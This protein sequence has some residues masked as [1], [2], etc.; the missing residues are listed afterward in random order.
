M[1][2]TTLGF[3]SEFSLGESTLGAADIIDI[4]ARLDQTHVAVADTMNVSIMIPLAKKAKGT[5]VEAIV[6][7]RLRI[8]Q[9]LTNRTKKGNR[10]AFFPKVYPKNEAGLQKIFALVSRAFTAD[11]FFH[12][13]RLSFDDM[14]E[15]LSGGDDVLVTSGDVDGIFSTRNHTQIVSRIKA[16][17]LDF[18]VELL[19]VP[20]PYYERCN[21]HAAAAIR[22]GAS[23][24]ISSPIFHDEDGYEAFYV[25]HAIHN[26]SLLNVDYTVSVPWTGFYPKAPVDVLRATAETVRGMK[27]IDPKV[28]GSMW[29]KAHAEGSKDFV[30]RAAY[31][32]AKREIALPSL[33]ADPN[34]A[35]VEACQAGVKA[36]LTTKVF[37][38]QPTVEEI[39]SK[40]VPRLKYELGVLKALGFADYFLVTADLCKWSKSNDVWTG[41]GRGSV[42]GSLVAYLMGITDVDPIRFDLI[43]E[44]FINPSR[45]DLPDADLDFMSARRGDVVKYLVSKYGE[46]YVAGINNYGSLQA[47]S[48]VNAVLRVHGVN[49]NDVTATKLVPKVHG[50]PVS[51][52]EAH[53]EVGEIQRFAKD[54]PVV[55]KQAIQMQGVM[56]MYSQHAAGTII[57]GVPLIERAIVESRNNVRKV[58]WDKDVCED[59]GLVKMDILGLSTLDILALAVQKVRQRSGARVD[60]SVI[61]LDDEAVLDSFGKGTT[62]GIFQVEGGA[63]RKILKGMA[64]GSPLTF[65]DIVAT[66]ALNRPGPIEAGLVQDYI[67][68]RNGNTIIGV[69]HPN[70]A[71]ALEDTHNVIV[72][73]EQ[74]MRVSVDLCG[75]SLSDADKLRKIMGKKQPEEMAKM[76]DQFV[77]GAVSH[78]GMAK[79]AADE[80]FDKIA[81]FAGYAFNKSHSVAYSLIGY[82]AM[83]MKVKHPIEFYAAAMTIA[84]DKK[85]PILVADAKNA[86]I[87]VMPPDINISTDVYEIVNDTTIYAPLSATKGVSATTARA[88]AA[89]RK[90]GEYKSIA[91]LE[92]RIGGRACNSGQRAA[93]NTVGAFARV[94]PGQR[95]SN[96][97]ERLKDQMTMLPGVMTGF[98]VADRKIPTDK[99]TIAYLRQIVDDIEAVNKLPN[100]EAKPQREQTIFARPTMGDRAKFMCVTDGP[101]R[102]EELSQRFADGE[103]FGITSSALITAELSRRD[104]YWTGLLK[105]RKSGKIVTGQEIREFSPY[106]DREVDLLKPPLIVTLGSNAARYFVPDLKGPIDE[107]VGRTFWDA[108]RDATILI[109]V[110][111]M[112]VM[113]DPDRFDELAWVF[114]LSRQIVGL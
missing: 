54:N 62:V 36:R 50:V 31:R 82:Q 24:F 46:D 86:G 87:T 60:L 98:I 44:R 113:M 35:L 99:Y 40:Y 9:D 38:Y 100:G 17:G 33:A 78:S 72:Y 53:E 83:W 110:N 90:N 1:T 55:W 12:V 69:P 104:A 37:G 103:D 61:P 10:D 51:L 16:A 93:L 89:E 23:A 65:N 22:A 75:F 14:L 52:E 79:E 64:E 85:L 81:L 26:R 107:Y 42:G 112:V 105:R 34:K 66:N 114:E 29:Q 92:G 106:L 80:L 45:N 41:P 11:R 91:D 43:F 73:Q 4:A 97:V 70:M 20:T 49:A 108:K 7:C 47:A 32:W 58:N 74:V 2:I 77:D 21:T 102:S 59:Q 67:D 28:D 15:V 94:E 6:G 95:A 71:P 68:S 13:P 8:V 48:S 18:M 27:T 56:N 109:G 19:P 63:A 25:N 76:R 39:S 57:S 96:D 111:P 101:F 84:D 3:R 88:I 5:G 30:R